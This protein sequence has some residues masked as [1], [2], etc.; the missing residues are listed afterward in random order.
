MK[1]Y[2]RA[3]QKRN[4][5]SSMVNYTIDLV[6]GEKV[7]FNRQSKARIISNNSKNDGEG[8]CQ[9]GRDCSSDWFCS[10][11]HQQNFQGKRICDDRLS[12]ENSRELG[13]RGRDKVKDQKIKDAA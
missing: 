9:S 1:K 12:I 7:L 5:L 3:K 2:E 13:I 11:K 4:F 10:S 8:W 6:D